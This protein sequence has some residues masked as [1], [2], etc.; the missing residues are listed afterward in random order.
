M[1][2]TI[3]L[4]KNAYSYFNIS[5]Y[6]YSIS[7]TY[8]FLGL[9]SVNLTYEFINSYKHKYLIIGSVFISIIALVGGQFLVERFLNFG[10]TLSV[11]I[12]FIG[13]IYFMYLLLK[14]SKL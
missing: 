5:I 1:F 3:K 2:P 11:I 14:E 13:G 8:N 9:L 4:L 10:T 12:N 6:I 7:R